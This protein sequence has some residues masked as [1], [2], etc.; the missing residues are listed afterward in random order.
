[1][2][3]NKKIISS[4]SFILC[5]F[6]VGCMTQTMHKNKCSYYKETVSS[7]LISEDNSS[8][9]AIG[10]KYHYVLKNVENVS[11]IIKSPLHKKLKLK[12]ID[13]NIN[14]D[15]TITGSFRIVIIDP[16]KYEYSE[17]VNY[18][19]VKDNNNMFLDFKLNGTRYLS[20]DIV[21]KEKYLL[22]DQYSISVSEPESGTKKAL[23][24]AATPIT[25]AI[26]GA[27]F[28]SHVPVVVLLLTF[29]ELR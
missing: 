23:K 26:D 22:N 24:I 27:L 12:F 4:M 21:L 14:H 29:E 19:F 3:R 16:N 8:L 17:A 20:G 7:I 11:S 15:N 25:A 9:V 18:G 10:E 1:M 2:F 13:A 28:L 5:F 6:L